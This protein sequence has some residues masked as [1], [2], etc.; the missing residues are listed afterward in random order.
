MDLLVVPSLNEGTPLVVL[1]AMS[2]GIPI[3]ASAVGGIPEQV[4]HGREALLV[5]PADPRALAGAVTT[6]LRQPEL[7][8]M[9]GQGARQRAVECFSPETL[10]LRTE[11]V[12]RA[13]LRTPLRMT[14]EH[15]EL[16]P[17]SAR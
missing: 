12:Y 15:L 7:A 3:V 4:R 5:S 13:A 8:H 17:P 11:D 6:L 10:R 16:A 2:A 1:E 9:L 14:T